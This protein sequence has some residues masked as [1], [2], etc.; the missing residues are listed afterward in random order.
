M[1]DDRPMTTEFASVPA[2][3]AQVISHVEGR[4]LP[5]LRVLFVVPR[6]RVGGA[7]R[8]VATLL[9]HLDPKRFEPSLLSLG[10][11]GRN[12]DDV[13]AAGV[14]ARALHRTRR[15]LALT[16]FQVIRHLQRVRPDVIVLQGA[17][18]EAIGRLAAVLTRTPRTVIWVHNCGDV[19][20][21]GHIR[22]ICDR[23]LE[24]V[25]SAYYGV[26][27]AQRTY[28]TQE[29]RYPNAKI[30]IIHNGVDPAPFDSAHA[31]NQDDP[32]SKEFSAN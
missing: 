32:L 7:E 23:I 8:H 1:H 20:P 11:G 2:V 16:L 29:L 31:K 27:Q 6:L 5:P 12:F 13:V 21:R 10:E 3:D 19:T 28:L 24:P 15:G 22:R 17:N 4:P 25:T 18:A 30:R 9:T 14:P 26:A